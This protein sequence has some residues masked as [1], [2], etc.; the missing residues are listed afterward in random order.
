MSKGDGYR[1]GNTRMFNIRVPEYLHGQFKQIC[2]DADV[3]MASA[4]IGYMERIVDG[5]E[6]IGGKSKENSEFDPLADIRTQYKDGED[7]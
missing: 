3:T 4:L 1:S 7:F 5:T 2:L 6:D